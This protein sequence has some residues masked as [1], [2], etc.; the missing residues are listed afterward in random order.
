MFYSFVTQCPRV[1]L[2]QFAPLSATATSTGNILKMSDLDHMFPY[3]FVSV[4]DE[5]NN[6]WRWSILNNRSSVRSVAGG[7]SISMLTLAQ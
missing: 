3:L 6:F 7:L 1:V 5:E 4:S 2:V